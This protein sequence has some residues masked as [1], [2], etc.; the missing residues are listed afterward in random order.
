MRPPTKDPENNKDAVAGRM[1]RL[2]RFLTSF[3]RV[4]CAHRFDP[5]DMENHRKTDGTI[6]W[7]C[8]QC[9]KQFSEECGMNVLSHGAVE[10]RPDRKGDLWG[11][12]K[13]NKELTDGQ[14][15]PPNKRSV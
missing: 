3:R 11:Y 6:K 12:S 1:E 14:P 10:K 5:A 13:P 4:T 9:G 7:V 8:W 2:V 15:V